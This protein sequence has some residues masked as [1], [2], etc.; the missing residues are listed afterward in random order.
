MVA[1]V[2]LGF[3]QDTTTDYLLRLRAEKGIGQV[4]RP[5][6]APWHNAVLKNESN[7]REALVRVALAGLYPRADTPKNWD[8]V[9]ALDC[10]LENTTQEA[11]I[12]DAGA[13]SYSVILP[14]LALN[15]YRN[16]IRINLAFEGKKTEGP[17]VYEYGDITKTEYPD[18]HFDAITCMSVV[19]HGVD[20]AAYFAE[21]NRILRP[22]GVLVTSTDYWETPIDTKGKTCFEVPVHVFNEAEVRTAIGVAEEKGF[23]Q[24]GPLDLSCDEKV[25]HW[26]E[27]DLRFT[28]LIVTLCKRIVPDPM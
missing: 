24:T 12:L 3:M 22:G 5:P 25:V 9:A 27:V 16:L 21:M 14:W 18:N 20:L 2:G 19:E 28:F 15:G 11:R 17:I 26:K 1:D 6:N 8:S 10:V 23:E 13:E 7:V 4:A